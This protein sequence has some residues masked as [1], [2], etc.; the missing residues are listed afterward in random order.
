M[1]HFQTTLHIHA[2]NSKRTDAQ[3]CHHSWTI[4]HLS[5]FGSMNVYGLP[6]RRVGKLSV[7][8]LMQAVLR[9]CM[10]V[11]YSANDVPAGEATETHGAP[12]EA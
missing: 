2:V 1:T 11:C 6:N 8:V 3:N 5:V 7:T 12:S 10:C 9:W 4:S